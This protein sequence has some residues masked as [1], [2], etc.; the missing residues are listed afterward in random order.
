[1]VKTDWLGTRRAAKVV[2]KVAL[3]PD[4]RVV[5][6]NN[7]QSPSPDNVPFVIFVVT[8]FRSPVMSEQALQYPTVWYFSR[9]V[10]LPVGQ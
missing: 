10:Q 4:G 7:P 8:T 3:T 9:N 5:L 1:M 2:A 6:N